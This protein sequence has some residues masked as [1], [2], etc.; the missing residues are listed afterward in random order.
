MGR[1]DEARTQRWSA[2]VRSLRVDLLREHLRRLPD[3]EDFAAERD[4][5]ALAARHQDP[6]CALAFLVDWPAL[7]TAAGLV[8]AR[9]GELD[10]GDYHTLTRAAEALAGRH[11]LAATLLFRRMTEDILRRAA[12]GQYRYAVHYVHECAALSARLAPD[13]QIEPHDTFVQRL[14]RAHGRKYKFWQ[15]LGER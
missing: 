1:K 13:A 12:A 9:L 2:F 14:R 6:H 15:L 5:V 11:P 4:A 10:G 7:Q 8:R 3:F